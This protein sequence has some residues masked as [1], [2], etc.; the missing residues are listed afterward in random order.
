MG[1][2]KSLIAAMSLLSMS[3]DI[4]G[5]IRGKNLVT[6]SNISDITEHV[7]IIPDHLIRQPWCSCSYHAWPE[8]RTPVDGDQ[9]RKQTSDRMKIDNGGH[10]QSN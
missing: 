5:A 9:K 1:E 8:E 3:D 6:V 7:H 4:M 2:K 10:R